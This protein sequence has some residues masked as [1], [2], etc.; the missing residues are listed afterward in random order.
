MSR[1]LNSAHSSTAATC[2]LNDVPVAGIA[3]QLLPDANALAVAEAVKARMTQLAVELAAGRVS[4]F[5]PYDSTDFI[6]IS[7]NE[8]VKTLIEAIILVFLVMLVFLQNLRATL[9]PTLVVPVALMGAFIGMYAFGFTINQ[10]TLFG[11][12]LAIGIVVDDA[13]VVIENVERIMRE[14][15]LPPRRRPARRCGRSPA[16]SSRSPRCWPPCSFR[17]R[18]R[19][20]ASASSIASS[21]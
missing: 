9:I 2:S 8:V 11:M 13:I 12:V 16:R 1:A 10:L 21:R 18:C 7:I 15:K 14:E 5:V 20:A 3:M 6:N 4:W 19:A 17:A